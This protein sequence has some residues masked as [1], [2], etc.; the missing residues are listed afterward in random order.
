VPAAS[1]SAEER[2]GNVVLQT[3]AAVHKAWGYVETYGPGLVTVLLIMFVAWMLS[4]WARRTTRRALE[5]ARFD[6]TLTKFIANMV[7]WLILAVAVVMCLGR[8]GIQTASF[9]ALIGA[10]GLAIGLGFQ[11]SLS[12]LAAG[13]MLLIFRP[14]KVGDVVSV[15]GQLGIVNEIDLFTTEIDTP[16]GRRV[17][18]PNGQIFGNV[19]ENITHHPRRRVDVPVGVAYGADIDQTR[20]VLE[21]AVKSIP[22]VLADPVPQVWLDGLGDSSVNWVVRVWAARDT[23]GDVRQATVRGVKMALDQ[24]GIEI[25]FPQRDVYIRQMAAPAARSSGEA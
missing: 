25:P 13:V 16:D 10:A 2:L 5:R 1:K 11:G 18:L 4:A 19:I 14:F 9:A 17:I 20:D 12:N 8:F 21:R 24:A 6:L 23:F 7:R 22:G 3:D 15:A